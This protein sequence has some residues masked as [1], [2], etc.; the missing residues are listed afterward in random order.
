MRLYLLRH[1]K[2]SIE[3]G[4][5]YGS[6]DLAVPIGE[7]ERVIDAI[8]PLLSRLPPGVPIY[9]SPLRRCREL[10]AALA[11]RLMLRKPVIDAR[12]AEMHFGAWE[13]QPWDRIPRAEVDAWA[14]DL[15]GYRPGGGERV[16]D[17]A[18]RV[19]AFLADLPPADADGDAAVIVAHAG[20]MRLLK[21]CVRGGPTRDIGLRAAQSRHDIAY[22]EL[23]ILE[24]RPGSSAG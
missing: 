18:A 7:Q 15:T 20:T 11:G 24:C 5:C 14:A 22:G 17:V 3:P 12:L 13:M 23:L 1:G 21:E 8:L 2:P 16:L 9:T 10:A 6:T 19:G 4:H